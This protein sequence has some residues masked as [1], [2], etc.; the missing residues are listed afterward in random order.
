MDTSLQLK[1]LKTSYIREILATTQDPK[2][3]SLAGG[4][5]AQ[6]LLPVNQLMK[7]INNLERTPEVFQYGETLGYKPLLEFISQ[8]YQVQNNNSVMV[9]TGSQQALDLIAR[10]YLNTGDKIA[11]EAPSYL[12]ALQVFDLARATICQIEQNRNGP[13]LDQLEQ[14]FSKGDVKLFYT[15]PD[16]HN[17]TGVCWSLETRKSVA[18]MCLRYGVALIEDIPYRELRFSGTELPLVSSFCPENAF[19]LRSLSKICAPGLRLG[20]VTAPSNWLAPLIRV[21]QAS[22][23]HTSLPMQAVALDFLSSKE[24]VTHLKKLRLNYQQRYHVLLNE[25]EPLLAEHCHCQAVEGGM[26]VWLKLIR[27]NAMQVSQALLKRNVAV[28]PG[29]VFYSE[30]QSSQQALRLNFTNCNSAELKLAAERLT[31]VIKQHS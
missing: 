13:D 5:P 22:E 27:A 31:E 19:V 8:K 3:L 12:G 18:A 21:K 16:F 4:L 2:V 7:S 10:A 23:L 15:V 24:F 26:F 1:N 9:C 11:V 28:V 25:I 17:P 29:S 30:S 14:V 20:M 6:E